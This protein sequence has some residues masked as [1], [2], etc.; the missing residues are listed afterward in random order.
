MMRKLLLVLFALAMTGD[1][2]AGPARESREPNP[3]VGTWRLIRYADTP[4]GGPAV[5]AFGESPIG[6]FIFTGDGHM[7][8]HITHNPPN[9]PNASVDPNPDACV[10]SWY[11]GYFGTYTV[12]PEGRYWV[13]QVLGGNVVSYIGTEQKRA[14]TLEGDRLVISATYLADGVEVQAERVLVREG[15]AQR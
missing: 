12:D 14:F 9:P 5:H 6:Q 4:Q 3:L 13:T 1:V 10:P 15:D 7:S 8:V 11:C 2:L